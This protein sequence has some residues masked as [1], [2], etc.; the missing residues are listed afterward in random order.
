MQRIKLFAVLGIVALLISAC[1]TGDNSDDTTTPTTTPPTDEITIPS[2]G[3]FKTM[4]DNLIAAAGG[5]SAT[6]AVPLTIDM[7]LGEKA[8]GSK[9]NWDVLMEV[10]YLAEKYV[11]L[12]LSDASC[13]DNIFDPD[14]DYTFGKDWITAIVLPNSATG[15]AAGYNDTYYGM[16]FRGFSK[17]DSISGSGITSIGAYAFMGIPLKSA[18]FPEATSV[19][20][21]AFYACLLLDT[22]DVPKLV[23]L[24]EAAFSFCDSLASVD[25]PAATTIGP[26]AFSSCT[27][28]AAVTM[29]SVTSVGNYAFYDTKLA[30]INLPAVTTIGNYAFSACPVAIVSLPATSIGQYAFSNCFELEEV[31][32]PSVTSIGNYA[33]QNCNVLEKVTLPATFTTLNEGV[34]YYCWKLNDIDL[35]KFTNIGN[36]AF[37]YCWELP[38]P[39]VFPAATVIGNYAFAYCNFESISLPLAKRIGNY[40]FANNESLDDPDLPL[41]GQATMSASGTYADYIGTNAFSNCTGL[42]TLNL[43]EARE[44]RNFAFEGCTALEDLYIEKAEWIYWGAFNYTG[45]QALTIHLGLQS[46][47]LWSQSAVTHASTPFIYNYSLPMFDGVTTPKTVT[48]KVPSGAKGYT[49][50][51]SEWADYA[52]WADVPFDSLRLPVTIDATSNPFPA[53]NPNDRYTFYHD[54]H[55]FLEDPTFVYDLVSLT[56]AVRTI[57]GYQPL[58]FGT[59]TF[60]EY[61][62]GYGIQ[63]DSNAFPRDLMGPRKVVQTIRPGFINMNITVTV[64]E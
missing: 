33:F 59:L 1:D 43:P 18:D 63:V 62:R 15:I 44:I 54:D 2:S 21:F 48:V 57:D 50:K 30:A 26:Y 46:P 14:K 20:T 49:V 47:T 35:T 53:L 3:P 31:N 39:L 34:F 16:T 42:V 52:T 28:L 58:Y 24:A 27:N 29:L 36:Y 6:N 64:T 51:D 13:D 19:G 12:D 41:A 38:D 7:D 37:Y 9:S 17:L 11:S 60:G 61:L 22:L 4:Y 23:T 10:L 55:Y 45:D 5:S 56:Y 25:L 40:A 8:D 32:L